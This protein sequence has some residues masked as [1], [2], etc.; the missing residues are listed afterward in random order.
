VVFYWLVK[1]KVINTILVYLFLVAACSS[2]SVTERETKRSQLDEMAATAIAGLV[3]QDAALQQKIDESLGYA[4][5]NMKVTKVPIVGAGGGEGVFV[6][7]RYRRWLGCAFVQ[8]IAGFRNS[9]ND[10]PVR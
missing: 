4:V 2:M 9:G 10:G 7:N 1:M 6:D 5:A 8:N 3:E